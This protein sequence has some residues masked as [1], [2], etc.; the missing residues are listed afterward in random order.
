[1]SGDTRAA[2]VIPARVSILTTVHNAGPYLRQTIDSALAQSFGGWEL[3][4]VDDG[5]TDDSR[6]ILASY[7]DARIRVDLLPQNVGRI[8][9]LR[10]AFALA[11][12]EYIAILDADDVAHPDR[13]A[14]QVAVLDTSPRTMMVGSWA[15]RINEH[16]VALGVWQPPVE[17]RRLRDALAWG[18][19]FVHSSVTFRRG[20]AEEVGGYRLDLPWAN[21]YGL[22]IRLAQRGEI[23]MIADILC[24]WRIVGTSMTRGARHRVDVV[25]DSL[26]LLREAGDRLAFAG[27]AKIRNRHAITLAEIK[28]GLTRLRSGGAL[29][30]LATIARAITLDPLAL[31]RWHRFRNEHL[32]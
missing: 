31:G 15:R 19:P 2:G 20:D 28:S 14:R 6:D 30:G 5:S 7:A 24:D 18:N 3:I 12:G 1:M 26:V 23:A 9:A 4:L 17:P 22:W 29:G 16:G 27:E 11:R 21:D 32:R 25:R 8:R 10:H 13:L